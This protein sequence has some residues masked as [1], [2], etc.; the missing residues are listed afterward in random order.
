M[1]VRAAI[2]LPAVGLTVIASDRISLCCR[3][4]THSLLIFCHRSSKRGCQGPLPRCREGYHW[5]NGRLS[6]GDVTLRNPAYDIGHTL[7][8]SSASIGMAI[9]CTCFERKIDLL[10]LS[11][12]RVHVF[13]NRQVWR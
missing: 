9:A 3:G 11:M 13:L 1:P 6:L 12:P 2:W 7:L 5:L 10:L 4:G 8:C